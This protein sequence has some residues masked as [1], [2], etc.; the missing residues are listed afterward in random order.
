MCDAFSWDLSSNSMMAIHPKILFAH[1]KVI[2]HSV[3]AIVP[4]IELEALL[5]AQYAGQLNLR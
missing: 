2:T 5:Y 3:D 4:R 1:N